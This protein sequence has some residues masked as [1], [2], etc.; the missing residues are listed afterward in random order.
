MAETE[1]GG[2]GKVGKNDVQHFRKEEVKYYINV[3]QIKR[4]EKT[5]S[6]GIAYCRVCSCEM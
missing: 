6:R 5:N 4:Q 3:K 1:E 2:R